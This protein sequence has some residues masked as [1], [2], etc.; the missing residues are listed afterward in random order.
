MYRAETS[1]YNRTMSTNKEVNMDYKKLVK[2]LEKAGMTKAQ[3][4][5]QAARHMIVEYGRMA[6]LAKYGKVIL[7]ADA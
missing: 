6:A 2:T 7:K 5:R 3:A 4:E 1:G